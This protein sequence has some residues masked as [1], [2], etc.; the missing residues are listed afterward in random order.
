VNVAGKRLFEGKYARWTL[1]PGRGQRLAR[2]SRR[3]GDGGGRGVVFLSG[4]EVEVLERWEVRYSV[5]SLVGC[6]IWEGRN[7]PWCFKLRCRRRIQLSSTLIEL[8][9]SVTM[10]LPRVC[11]ARDCT[12]G[13]L[14]MELNF[15]SF[16]PAT[17]PAPMNDL[18]PFRIPITSISPCFVLVV[19][20]GRKGEGTI[21]VVCE[22]AASWIWLVVGRGL[23]GQTTDGRRV[24]LG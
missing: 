22:G 6:L 2:I 7:V 12:D 4:E 24:I 10:L 3:R 21:T 8:G 19:N 1:L 20:R 9:G 16:P 5:V 14:V 15:E 23:R 11:K 18:F 13:R 17:P